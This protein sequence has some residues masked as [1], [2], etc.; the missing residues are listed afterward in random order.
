MD[1]TSTIQRDLI[2]QFHLRPETWRCDCGAV[3]YVKPSPTKEWPYG[4]ITESED[5]GSRWRYV[6]G[7]WEHHHGYPVGHVKTRRAGS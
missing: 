2:E 5:P 7:V 4:I 1:T 6:D 3:L